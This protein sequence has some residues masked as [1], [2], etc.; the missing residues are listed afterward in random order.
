MGRC[1]SI[2][3]EDGVPKRPDM[4]GSICP[5]NKN[6]LRKR[7]RK[8]DSEFNIWIFGFFFLAFLLLVLLFAILVWYLGKKLEIYYIRAL[9]QIATDMIILIAI[10]TII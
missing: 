8:M 3:S 6:D 10:N 4:V 9:R 2:D 1:D 5:N 7:G